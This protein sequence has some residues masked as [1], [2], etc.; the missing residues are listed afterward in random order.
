MNYEYDHLFKLLLIGDSGV[1]KSAILER[2]CDDVFSDTQITTIGVDFKIKTEEIDGK[3]IKLQMWDT[4][5]QERFKGIVS[6]YYRGGEGI[7]VVYDVSDRKSFTNI[8]YWLREVEKYGRSDPRPI[9]YIIGNKTDLKRAI[10]LHEAEEF[11]KSCGAK[12]LEVSAKKDINIGKIFAEISVDLMER[13]K[14]IKQNKEAQKIPESKPME[15]SS[16]CWVS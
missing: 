12:Y 1:G 6:S 16:C 13:F 2:Y 10:S 3:V 5:G 14:T 15:L 9:I 8:I 7:F 11:A 4:A